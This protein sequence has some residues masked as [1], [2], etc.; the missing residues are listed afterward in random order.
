[1]SSDKQLGC[2]SLMN[3]DGNVAINSLGTPILFLVFNRPDT[4]RRVFEAIRNA[5]PERLY[6]AADG[7]R[8]SRPGET[9][10]V[11]EVRQIVS[12]VDWPCEVKTLFRETNLGCKKAVSSAISWFFEHEPEGIILEDDCVPHA[13]FFSFCAELLERY[14]D[15]ERISVISGSPLIDC[16]EPTECTKSDFFFSRH[17]S[18]WGWASWR[19]FWVDYDV[20]MAEW[21][22]VRRA[23]LPTFSN[24]I[25]QKK[26]LDVF[27]SVYDGK[28]DTWDYQVGYASWRTGRVAILPRIRLIENIGFGDDATHTK[29]K[30]APIA[31]LAKI[32]EKSFQFPLNGPTHFIRNMAYEINL[33]HYVT[34]SKLSRLIDYTINFIKGCKE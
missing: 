9:E 20:N 28:V 22:S 8:T 17:F 2:S 18:I 34:R 5:R 33:E 23:M 4:T 29:F 31:Q 26:V 25:Y 3:L 1:M 30:S 10:R 21:P 14:R 32:D 15:D 12:N 19:R 11:N 16:R 6:L 24:K 27:S 13:Q 7:V